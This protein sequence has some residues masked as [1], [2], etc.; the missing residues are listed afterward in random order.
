MVVVLAALHHVD[1]VL[2]GDNSG[3]PFTSDFTP[4]TVSLVVYPIFVLDFLLLRDRRWARVG[5]VA[6]LFVVLQVAHSVL[7]RPADQYSTWADG[8]SSVPHAFGE[9]NLLGRAVPALGVASVALSVLLSVAVLV[10]LVLLGREARRA[11]SPSTRPT[12]PPG[13]T[14]PPR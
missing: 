10:A 3:W 11:E 13:Q 6:F 8:V 14:A 12:G 7:E 5:L 1:H 9:P 2:R 4:F